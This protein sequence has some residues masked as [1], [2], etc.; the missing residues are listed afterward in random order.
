MNAIFKNKQT[1]WGH[2]QDAASQKSLSSRTVYNVPTVH[3]SE[4]RVVFSVDWMPFCECEQALSVLAFQFK[5]TY[6]SYF[7]QNSLVCTEKSWFL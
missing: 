3:V 4:V 2:T 1:T 6:I 5:R 7:T